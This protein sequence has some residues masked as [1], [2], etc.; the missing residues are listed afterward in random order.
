MGVPR[1]KHCEWKIKRLQVLGDKMGTPQR[2]VGKVL[3]KKR[4]HLPSIGL[5]HVKLRF[6]NFGVSSNYPEGLKKMSRLY[7]WRLTGLGKG[8]S[9]CA[10]NRCPRC[11]SMEAKGPIWGNTI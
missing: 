7:P 2:D 11:L 4:H 8:P 9:M 10:F 1:R 5:Y 3:P 6:L